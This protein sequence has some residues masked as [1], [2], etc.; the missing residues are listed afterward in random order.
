MSYRGLVV[1]K[2]EGKG[3][4]VGPKRRWKDNIKID[5]KN[6]MQVRGRY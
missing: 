5:I 1:G 6:R 4:L 3:P 2:H